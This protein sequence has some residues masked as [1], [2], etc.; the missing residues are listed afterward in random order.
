M[1]D[2]GLRRPRKGS[3]SVLQFP[4][5]LG[6][7]REFTIPGLREDKIEAE[8]VFRLVPELDAVELAQGA[9]EDPISRVTV[10][11]DIVW[12]GLALFVVVFDRGLIGLD[13]WLAR[14]I[15]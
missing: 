5:E 2:S 4:I 10:L 9:E 3:D 13:R 1:Q 15:S 14:R 7:D 8:D 11:R 12:L 6:D